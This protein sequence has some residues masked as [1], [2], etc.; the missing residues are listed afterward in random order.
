MR[1]E[2]MNER[3]DKMRSNVAFSKVAF[4]MRLII[5]LV[6]VFMLA[7]TPLASATITVSMSA[8]STV[9]QGSNIPVS[10]SFVAGEGDSGTFYFTCDQTTSGEVSPESGYSVSASTSKTYTFT[11]SQAQTY[12]NCK[13]SDGGTQSSSTYTITAIAPTSLTV[14]GSPEATSS[15]SFTLTITV[16]NPTGDAVTTSYVLT[17][18]SGITCTG[19]QTSATITIGSGSSTSLE[20]SVS[21]SSSGT[22]TFQLGS[23][24]NAFSSVVTLPTTT[25]TTQATTTTTSA[26]VGG[27]DTTTTSTTATT[28]STTSTTTTTLPPTEEMIL[29]EDVT[30]DE[31]ATFDFIEED[32][33]K[34][35]SVVIMAKVPMNF[36]GVTVKESSLPSGVSEPFTAET[37]SVYKYLE[38]T[39]DFFT[40]DNITNA[41]ID[42]KVE[43]SWITSN[44]VD[45]NA[46]ALFR[47]SDGQWNM[48]STS[49]VSEDS[50]YV[51]YQAE[52]ANLSMFAI[53]A[54]KATI[55]GAVPASGE[56][57]T[58]GAKK[59]F[60]P[61]LN[62]PQILIIIAIIVGSV[63]LVLIKLEII[64]I[65]MADTPKTLKDVKE[66][67]TKGDKKSKRWKELQE[68]YKK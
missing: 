39:K 47:Y 15:S 56:E 61:K 63:F 9:T 36:M 28:T 27:F 37:G 54:P 50:T 10:A 24:S 62:F 42:F 51:H 5:T 16:T 19:D 14:E 31:E 59:S 38:L 55:T 23:N 30:A 34:I 57:D 64:E 46:V 22:A 35:K 48:L 7:L 29:L 4:I 12:Q 43:K 53:G 65:T 49:L 44:E 67:K 8:P 13:V 6:S 26:S 25:T 66:K 11:P 21:A 58:A 2:L 1:Y 17:C 33:L 68:K 32:T 18:P 40:D 52:T 60:M 41:K 3:R 45:S 20:W